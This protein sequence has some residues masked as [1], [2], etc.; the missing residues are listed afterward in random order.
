MPSR[1][2]A[3]LERLKVPSQGFSQMVFEEISAHLGVN[4]E[5]TLAWMFTRSC[6]QLWFTNGLQCHLRQV[7][8]PFYA[9]NLL[10]VSSRELRCGRRECLPQGKA[11]GGRVQ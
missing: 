1:L 8:P 3:E 5:Y 10:H 11:T 7:L 6:P 4:E 2:R 9:S